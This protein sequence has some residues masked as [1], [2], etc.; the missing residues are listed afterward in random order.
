[1]SFLRVDKDF[2]PTVYFLFLLPQVLILGLLNEYFISFM[3]LIN[4]E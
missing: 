1:M 4:S 3:S 2:C